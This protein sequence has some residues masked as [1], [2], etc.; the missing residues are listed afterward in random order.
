MAGRAATG[1]QSKDSE[2]CPLD[3]TRPTADHCEHEA[4]EIEGQAAGSTS[5]SASDETTRRAPDR[6]NP[7]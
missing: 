7:Q 2:P 5:T 6:G 1:A 3:P 4:D